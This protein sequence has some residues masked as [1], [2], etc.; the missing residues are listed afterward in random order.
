MDAVDRCF[1]CARAPRK[2]WLTCRSTRGAIPCLIHCN[3]IARANNNERSHWICV[4]MRKSAECAEVISMVTAWQAIF[5]MIRDVFGVCCA[6]LILRRWGM[7]SHGRNSRWP[8][9]TG[10]NNNTA[11]GGNEMKCKLIQTHNTLLSICNTYTMSFLCF[12]CFAY[13]AM[14]LCLDTGHGWTCDWR[15]SWVAETGEYMLILQYFRRS[16]G[17][18][19]GERK[20]CSGI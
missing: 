17:R 18:L 14:W 6:W 19:W 8:R 2:Q 3:K 4:R 9:Q 16:F 13:V 15:R 5:M 1:V 12:V 10:N 7:I 20:G 11:A